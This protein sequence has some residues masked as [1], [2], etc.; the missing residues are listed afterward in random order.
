MTPTN[1]VDRCN[2]WLVTALRYMSPT[3]RRR[4]CG[5]MFTF[6]N[7]TI[8]ASRQVTIVKHPV[9][10]FR[11]VKMVRNAIFNYPN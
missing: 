1:Q 10:S 2:S 7:V 9:H 6:H 5:F 3:S 11:P 8:D 4:T